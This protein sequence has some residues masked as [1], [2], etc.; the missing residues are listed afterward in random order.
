MDKDGTT[1]GSTLETG[2]VEDLLKKDFK[3]L[4]TWTFGST[5]GEGNRGVQLPNPV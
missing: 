5:E 1:H 4:Q 3:N 2:A